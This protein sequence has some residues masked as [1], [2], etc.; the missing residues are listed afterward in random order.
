MLLIL[1]FYAPCCCVFQNTTLIPFLGHDSRITGLQVAPDGTA[2]ATCSWDTTLKVGISVSRVV[3]SVALLAK[4]LLWSRFGLESVSHRSVLHFWCHPK[5][6][7]SGSRMASWHQRECRIIILVK[8]LIGVCVYKN[9]TVLFKCQYLLVI[10]KLNYLL[11]FCDFG[12]NVVNPD[13]DANSVTCCVVVV[14]VAGGV[15]TMQH[16]FQQQ[17]RLPTRN[18][19][20]KHCQTHCFSGLL[21]IAVAILSIVFK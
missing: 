5:H 2:V 12:C 17:L 14:V 7:K 9:E 3:T 8:W 13:H 16:F 4:R 21:T 20:N 18:H 6:T 10:M 11:L 1:A 19:E 15:S